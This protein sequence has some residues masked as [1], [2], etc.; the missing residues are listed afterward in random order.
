LRRAGKG[1]Y[2]VLGNILP[3]GVRLTMKTSERGGGKRVKE[4]DEGE[5]KEEGNLISGLS[6][7][8]GCTWPRQG[9]GCRVERSYATP[10]DGVVHLD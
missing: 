1:F 5:D 8:R 6:I 2:V 9:G 7:Q 3:C 10:M 4:E